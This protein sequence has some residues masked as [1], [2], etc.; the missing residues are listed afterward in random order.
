MNFQI[1]KKNSER[2]N[3]IF[4]GNK[5]ISLILLTTYHTNKSSKQQKNSNKSNNKMLY[6]KYL[7][8]I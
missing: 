2:I 1:L 6:N 5:N 8:V 7:F 4:H 3:L